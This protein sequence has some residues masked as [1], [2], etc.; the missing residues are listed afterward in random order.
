LLTYTDF[1]TP[2]MYRKPTPLQNGPLVA[3]WEIILNSSIRFAV[4]KVLESLI[5]VRIFYSKALS[6]GVAVVNIEITEATASHRGLRCATKR[7]VMQWRCARTAS[8]ETLRQIALSTHGALGS[9][10]LIIDTRC[11]KKQYTVL[12]LSDSAQ[13]QDHHVQ[14]QG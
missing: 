11:S 4:S 5:F 2:Y 14:R 10:V 13:C 7:C 6:V 1:N 3:G 9:N 8:R 12:L